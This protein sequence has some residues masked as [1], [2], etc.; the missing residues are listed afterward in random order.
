[1]TVELAYRSYGEGP[2]IVI[3]HGLFGSG[4]NWHACAKRLAERYRVLAV[5][6][7][8]HGRSPWADKMTY[9]H[10]IDDIRSL[11][12]RQD[13]GNA[14]ILGHSMGGKVAMLCSLL[15]SHLVDALIVVDIAPV[16]YAHSYTPY[17]DALKRLDLSGRPGRSELENQLVEDIPDEATRKFLMQNLVSHKGQFAWRVNL[18]AIRAHMTDLTGFPELDDL[19]FDGPSLFIHG[20]RSDYVQPHHEEHIRMNFPLAEFAV[21]DDAGH[22]VH[23][24]QPDRFVS[25]IDT[26]LRRAVV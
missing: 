17:I 9:S 7:R 15:Y 26:F 19:P 3:L 18:D 16:R 22:R 12:V 21:I 8:N 2:P 4:R 5:D 14:T 23:V 25:R 11:L 10:M 24:D 6:L 13:I 20:D 1:M